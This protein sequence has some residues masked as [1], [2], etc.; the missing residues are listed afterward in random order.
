MNF[1]L[2]DEQRML[3]NSLERFIASRYGLDRR[4]QWQRGPGGFSRENW[5]LLADMGLLALPFSAQ[6]GGLGGTAVDIMVVMEQIGRGL[7]VEPFAS[8][9]V[10]CG[11]LAPPALRA[12]IIDGDAI[13]ALAH[14]ERAGRYLWDHCATSLVRSNDHW[15]LSGEKTLVLAGMDAD[16]LLVVARA[17]EGLTL[18]AL[19]PGAGGVHRRAYRTADGGTAC[20]L[21]L[22]QVAVPGHA[23]VTAPGDAWPLLEA[24]YAATCLALCAE[25]IGA[26]EALFA[27]TLDYVRARQQFGQPIGRFQAVQHRLAD[28]YMAL[29][30]A[31]SLTLKAVLTPEADARAWHCAIAGAK[32]YVSEVALKLGHE[33]VQFHGGMGMTDELVVSHYHKRLLMIASLFGDQAFQLKRYAGLAA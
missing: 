11:R 21:A 22:H 33:A 19:D 25:A 23:L 7:I 10:L 8:A 2:S 24:A 20:E 5:R 14:A 16:V 27:L 4:R 29:E 26:M 18:V 1:E 13:P 30:Q 28:C 17:P 3:K 31:R 9:V 6:D 12:R 15:Q 32:A